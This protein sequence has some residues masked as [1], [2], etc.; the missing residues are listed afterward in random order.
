[1]STEQKKKGHGCLI[2]VIVFL[3][4]C[5]GF[6]MSIMKAYEKETTE[7]TE[8][9]TS[10]ADVYVNAMDFKEI[11]ESDC[12]ALVGEPN[13][14]EEWNYEKNGTYVPCKSYYYDKYELVFMR[15]TDETY[16]CV[17]MKVYDKDILFDK[18]TVVQQFGFDKTRN[19]KDTGVSYRCDAISSEH[20]AAV[21]FW[22][23]CYEDGKIKMLDITYFNNVF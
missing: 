18:E 19:V 8:V 10:V 9:E 22:I 3:L 16:A 5:V 2:T 1:M 7:S 15:N 20:N 11:S 13:S 12:V 14:I 17:R 23:S 21:D 6:T 4:V